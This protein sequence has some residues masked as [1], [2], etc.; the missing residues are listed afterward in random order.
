M[1]VTNNSAP[2]YIHRV[3]DSVKATGVA[4]RATQLD[5]WWYPVQ[6]GGA[7][8]GSQHPDWCVSDWVLPEEFYPNGQGGLRKRQG[9]P[10]MMY[11]PNLCVDNAWNKV[12]KM[13]SWPRSWANSSLL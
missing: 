10:L 1:S 7:A 11:F 8:P 4:P 13:P 2:S 9:V 12:R 5:C 6:T 3:A